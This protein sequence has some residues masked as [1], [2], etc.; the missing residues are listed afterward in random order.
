ITEE[1]A[2]RAQLLADQ[3]LAAGKPGHDSAE[4]DGTVERHVTT[5]APTKQP[6]PAPRHSAKLSISKTELTLE[7]DEHHQKPKSP[8]SKIPELSKISANICEDQ[9]PVKQL[10]VSASDSTEANQISMIPIPVDKQK[11]LEI[12]EDKVVA[13]IQNSIIENPSIASYS[14]PEDIVYTKTVTTVVSSE[15]DQN[16]IKK[17]LSTNE[18]SQVLEDVSQDFNKFPQLAEVSNYT[19]KTSKAFVNERI[20]LSRSKEDQMSEENASGSIVKEVRSISTKSSWESSTR[21]RDDHD[22]WETQYSLDTSP[23]SCDAGFTKN[24]D[25]R[26]DL[27]SD[28]D[29]EGSPRQR[30][31]SMSKRRT[32]GSSSGSDVALHEGAELSPMEDDQESDFLQHSEPS[33]METTTTEIDPLTNEKIT[34]TTRVITSSTTVPGTEEMVGNDELRES[35]QKVVD[36]FMTEERRAQ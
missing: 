36:Q 17:I 1:A 20:P 25:S 9:L 35:M 4:I 22:N 32:L 19:V 11:S 5:S 16:S 12:V 7:L 18:L 29:S 6:V 26:H 33:Y 34:R 3:A 28:S 27:P 15:V 13:T 8:K 14:F 21:S 2:K 23:G 10:R 24:S 30:R 31:R